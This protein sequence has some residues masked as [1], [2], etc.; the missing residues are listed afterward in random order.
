MKPRRRHWR[1]TNGGAFPSRPP[2][3]RPLDERETVP[4]SCAAGFRRASPPFCSRAYSCFSLYSPS[5]SCLYSTTRT[6]PMDP[7]SVI[8]PR[9]IIAPPT[10]NIS[11]HTA[12]LRAITTTIPIRPLPSFRASYNISILSLAQQATALAL[13]KPM[14]HNAYVL[15]QTA[16]LQTFHMGQEE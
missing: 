8:K 6:P 2:C 14:L 13:C 10:T 12:R 11:L 16:F 9:P 5:P 7:F 1:S 3:N 4:P 15:G